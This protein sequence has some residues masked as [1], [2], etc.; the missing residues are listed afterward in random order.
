MAHV[1]STEEA[2]EEQR[3]YHIFSFSHEF[4]DRR[5]STALLVSTKYISLGP[6]GKLIGDRSIVGT[7][8]TGRTKPRRS[9]VILA[10]CKSPAR[11]VPSYS[12]R[13]SLHLPHCH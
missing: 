10:Y 12:F 9:L 8:R 3:E 1:A 7:E 2:A 4:L 13:K 6:G 11:L 5:S